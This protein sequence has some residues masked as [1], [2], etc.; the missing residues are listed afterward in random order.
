MN[1]ILRFSFL[2]VLTMLFSMSYAQVTFDFDKDAECYKMFGL[3]GASSKTSTT[4]DFTESKTST[5]KDNI[6]LTVSAKTSG[7]NENRIW[8]T[9]PRLRMYSGTLTIASSA[10][11]ISKIIFK[12]GANASYAKWKATTTTGSLTDFVAGSTKEMV[13]TGSDKSVTLNVRANTQISMIEVYTT[14]T[15]VTVAKPTFVGNSKFT[16]TT[17]VTIKSASGTTVYYT[18]NGNTPDEN[19]EQ[20]S[21]PFAI[22][23]TTTVKAIAY[24][25]QGNSSEVAEM[26]Y[27]K[28][29]PIPTTGQGTEESPYTVSDICALNAAGLLP[30]KGVVTGTIYKVEKFDEKR[31]QINYYINTPG[32]ATTDTMM[33]YGGL[34]IGGE[35]FK[36]IT[37]LSVGDVVT[38]TGDIKLYNKLIEFN[39]GNKILKRVPTPSTSITGTKAQDSK[40]APVYNVSGQRV[41]SNYNGI[42]IKNGKKYFQK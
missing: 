8:N 13:W 6:T 11:N 32:G 7:K 18:T 31:G 15:A 41:N 30:E 20:Y 22:S 9:S 42:V 10:E 21:V 24:D 26:T 28:V 40:N 4:G 23:N 27:T 2:A 38:V 12:L 14:N 39:Y 36:A 19:G 5:P 1:K 3:S 33:V 34:N 37:D 25:G 17:N 16:T 35:K 29:D